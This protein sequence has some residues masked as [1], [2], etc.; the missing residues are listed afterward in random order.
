MEM[1]SNG[2]I[3]LKPIIGSQMEQFKNILV[4]F[5]LP[6]YGNIDGVCQNQ[7]D[8]YPLVYQSRYELSNQGKEWTDRQ[9][10]EI[11][12]ESH[13][14]DIHGE[15]KT[16]NLVCDAAISSI[17]LQEEKINIRKPSSQQEC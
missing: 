8:L 12:I 7:L 9:L 15:V 4:R 14:P 5:G 17:R 16:S 10:V 2:I 1:L 13:Y 11:F 6:E 3:S